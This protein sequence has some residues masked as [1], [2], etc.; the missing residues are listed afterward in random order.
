M[1]PGPFEAAVT[2]MSEF[3]SAL[4]WMNA[5][6]PHAWRPLKDSPMIGSPPLSLYTERSGSDF[7]T[8]WA[9]CSR[10]SNRPKMILHLTRLRLTIQGA[11][12]T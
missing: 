7:R 6:K 9:N 11:T 3:E 2:F 4:T 8:S 1:A 5:L 12:K 10:K